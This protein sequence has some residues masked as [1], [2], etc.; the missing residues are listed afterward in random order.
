MKFAAEL[1]EVVSGGCVIETNKDDVLLNGYWWMRRKDKDCPSL[2]IGFVVFNWKRVQLIGRYEKY[3]L[4]DW[5]L[6]Q[7]VPHLYENKDKI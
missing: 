7:R 4:D 1:M 2:E 6:L 3:N 5:E